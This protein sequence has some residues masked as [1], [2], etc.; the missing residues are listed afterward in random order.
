L[1]VEDVR[2][3]ARE[4]AT[5]V[6]DEAFSSPGKSLEEVHMTTKAAAKLALRRAPLR[7]TGGEKSSR[8]GGAERP[9]RSL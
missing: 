6:Y 3:E 4:A 1:P 8:G 9:Q 5:A 2:S 7:W